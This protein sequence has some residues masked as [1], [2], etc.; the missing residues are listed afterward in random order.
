[1]SRWGALR[2][3]A[4]R[5]PGPRG[6]QEVPRPAWGQRRPGRPTGRPNTP[7]APG[8]GHRSTG[9]WLA[10]RLAAPDR[11]G[12]PVDLVGARRTLRPR[13]N[14]LQRARQS[15]LPLRAKLR[16]EAALAVPA[17]GPST[18]R[19]PQRPY[20]ATV[21]DA[22]CPRP[23]LKE[24]TGAGSLPPCLSPA[25]QL[26]HEGPPPRPGVISAQPTL[27]PQARAPGGLLSRNWALASA[28]L[29]ASEGGG[30]TWRCTLERPNRPG[31]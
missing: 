8:P 28:P 29:V 15:P 20:G 2:R 30:A 7:H 21:D 27:R 10:R 24:R 19:G 26:H 31:A 13:A 14:A 12:E 16:D 17:T 1:M 18:G 6:R 4:G 9:G 5:Q 3:G 23:S 22:P 25:Q 11:R